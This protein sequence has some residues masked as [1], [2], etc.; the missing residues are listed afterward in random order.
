MTIIK[1]DVEKCLT[2]TSHD[3]RNPRSSYTFAFMS[4]TMFVL[5]SHCMSSGGYTEISLAS[6]AKSVCSENH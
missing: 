4:V 2:V 1:N 5:L 6:L 3:N